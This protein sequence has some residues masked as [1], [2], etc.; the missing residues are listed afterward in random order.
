MA[1]TVNLL[2]LNN[3]H[4]NS[5]THTRLE[6]CRDAYRGA[7]SLCKKYLI[8]FGAEAGHHDAKDVQEAA[9]Q[10]QPPRTK[11]IVHDADKRALKRNQH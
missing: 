2:L 10:E 1:E 9:N 3:E 6:D 7:Q 4:R 11:V 5:R 8:V